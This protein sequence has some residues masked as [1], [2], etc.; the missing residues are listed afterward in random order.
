MRYRQIEPSTGVTIAWQTVMIR[1]TLC[2]KDNCRTVNIRDDMIVVLLHCSV[3]WTQ[4]PFPRIR[5]HK[6]HLRKRNLKRQKTS[7]KRIQ[8]LTP[9]CHRKQN[10]SIRPPRIRCR[11]SPAI[12]YQESR[13]NQFLHRLPTKLC[14]NLAFRNPWLCPNLPFLQQTIKSQLPLLKLWKRKNPLRATFCNS[15]NTKIVTAALLTITGN[16][17][18]EINMDS[19]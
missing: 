9:T 14:Q 18:Q 6:C 13:Q 3:L 8:F 17:F 4:R 19:P 12:Q 5:I 15:C 16:W 7:P 2:A 11:Q 1:S 10:R